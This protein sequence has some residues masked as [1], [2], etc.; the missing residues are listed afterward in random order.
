MLV[1][2][3]HAGLSMNSILKRLSSHIAIS[4][5]SNMIIQSAFEQQ[6]L[7]LKLMLARMERAGLTLQHEKC[8]FVA[9]EVPY[10]GS[11]TEGVL[12]CR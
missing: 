7:D 8:V 9:H 3:K 5:L 11:I 6:V 12:S 1:G 4:K 2:L 10:L